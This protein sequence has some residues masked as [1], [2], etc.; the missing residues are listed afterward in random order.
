ME[1]AAVFRQY[2][3]GGTPLI[4]YELPRPDEHQP[5]PKPSR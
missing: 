3:I 4:V 5:Q 2:A 1:R